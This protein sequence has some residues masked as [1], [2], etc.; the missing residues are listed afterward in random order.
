MKKITSFLFLFLLAGVV[1][2]AQ[3]SIATDNSGPDPSAM[4]DV[5]S[6]DKGFLPPRMTTVQ[7]NGIVSPIS[8]LLV[9][10]TSVN[11]LYWYNGTNWQRFNEFNFTEIDPVFALHPANSVTTELLND[12]NTAFD[13]R[14]TV[15]SGTN[16]LSLSILNNQLTGSIQQANTSQ[17]GYI[18][19]SDWN[20]FNNKQNV[21][22]FGNLTSSDITVTGG[23]GAVKGSGATL[24]VKKSNLTETGSS[25]LTITNG[26][27]AVLGTTGT[28]LQVKQAGAS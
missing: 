26:A 19:S 15:A 28:T 10:N 14:I 12:W 20:T 2:Y 7:M 17:G 24:A 5:K 21:L 11:A 8:G 9:Y 27:N 6:S 3:V 23:T 18:S 4:L 1:S 16:P 22:T 25:V 13:S